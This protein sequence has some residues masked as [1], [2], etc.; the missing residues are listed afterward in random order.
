MDLANPLAQLRDARRNVQLRRQIQRVEKYF[1]LAESQK[2]ESKHPVLFFNASTRIHTLSLNGAFGL[3]ASWAIRAEGVPTDYIVCHRGMQ[4]CVLGTNRQNTLAPPPC[5]RC[6]RFSSGLFP[7]NRVIP[8]ILLN[9]TVEA[10]SAELLGQSLEWLMDWRYDG[11]P[12]GRLCLPGLRWT[13]R[14][15]HLPDDIATR[16]LYGQFL[17]SA[18]SLV[19]RFTEI[20]RQRRPRALVIFNG[21]FYPEA[22]ARQVALRMKVPV[23]T[24]EVGL[25]PMSAFF[26]RELATFRELELGGNSKLIPAQDQKLDNYLEERFSGR[27][28]MAGVRFWG[29]M[30]DLPEWALDRF[31]LFRQ[32]VIIFTN[33]VFDTSQA[34]ANT[35]YN[36]MFDWL[37]DLRGAFQKHPETLFVIRAHPD[38]D[39]PG[40]RSRESVELWIRE[41]DLQQ[42]NNVMFFGP[43]DQVSSYDLIR[44]CKLVLVY[45]SSIGLEASILGVPVLC[46]GRARFTQIPTV[47]QPE[48]REEYGTEL[49]TLLEQENVQAPSEF[50]TNARRFLYS[51]LYE[52][53]LDFSNFLRPLA[54]SPGM[55]NLAPFEPSS[56]ERDKNMEILRRGILDGAPFTYPE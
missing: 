2:T 48:T 3:L 27:F 20:L 24:H 37:E 38:E 17:L 43:S 32:T 29:E 16:Q 22:V 15:H 52:A 53:S 18:A 36:N 56:L 11:L 13:L 45:N 31:S 39:R 4:Q 23:I 21:I 26:S 9:Q 10:L 41:N 55:V 12:L 50:T 30:K 5:N 46:A 28:T 6:M 35:I 51:E 34:H 33:V 54:D 14:R 1:S 40:K 47:F 42:R 25:R 19:S 7:Q 8:L 49:H 44:R